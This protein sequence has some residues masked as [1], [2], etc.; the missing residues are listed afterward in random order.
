MEFYRIHSITFPLFRIQL[1][2]KQLLMVLNKE[3]NYFQLL[4]T[5]E[6]VKHSSCKM[7]K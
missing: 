6:K 5:N 2:D 1:F 7:Q 3:K 4:K